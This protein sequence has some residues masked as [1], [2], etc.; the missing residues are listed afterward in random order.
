MK[1]KILSALACSAMAS[2]LMACGDNGDMGLSILHFTVGEVDTTTN[3]CGFEASEDEYVP[4]PTMPVSNPV[5]HFT[6]KNSMPTPTDSGMGSLRTNQ[7]TATFLAYQFDCPS[8]SSESDF[9][10]N[11]G[12]SDDRDD[13]EGD[14]RTVP[15]WGPAIDPGDLGSVHAELTGPGGDTATTALIR[16]QV[17]GVTDS[18]K[19]VRSPIFTSM[20]N[21]NPLT[22]CTDPCW[23]KQ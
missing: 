18:G 9:C 15:V 10:S 14:Q 11:I 1:K 6:I 13:F 17:L 12:Y 20:V 16:M 21:F 23:C 7:V 4:S 5:V 19:K 22:S 2:G 3:S 8:G